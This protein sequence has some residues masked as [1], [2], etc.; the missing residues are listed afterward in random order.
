[1]PAWVCV[2]AGGFIGAV[3]R[4]ALSGAVSKAVGTSFPFG[5]L[6]VNLLGSLLIGVLMGLVE[7]RDAF[8]PE[9]RQFLIIGG[10]GGFTTFS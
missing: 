5:T 4:W 7:Y 8:S 6:A 10:L 3:A 9:Q 2:G 1:M